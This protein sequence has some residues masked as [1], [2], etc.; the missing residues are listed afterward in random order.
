MK[1]EKEQIELSNITSEKHEK[2]SG[3]FLYVLAM[4]F[5]IGLLVSNVAASNV[6]YTPFFV[7]LSAAEFIFPITYIV[8]DLLNE[9]F[10]MKKTIKI[11]LIGI[12]IVFISMVVLF[13]TTYLPT[14]YTE[15]QNVFGFFTSGVVGITI[16]SFIAYMSG[17]V[18]NSLI[19]GKLKQ[20]DKE[21]KFFKRAIL[22]SIVAELVDSLV[23]VTCCCIFAS[24]FYFWD[25]LLSLSITIFAIKIIV[26]IAIFPLTN[27]IRNKVIKHKW[28]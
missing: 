15:Y 9:F 14:G 1:K 2:D 7:S 26:E 24:Q 11:T 19:M 10:G 4:I 3:V 16:S 6:F 23:F 25:K 18:T 8:N 28:V 22:S 27:L 5:V 17:S 21:N 20:K 12:L 13:L